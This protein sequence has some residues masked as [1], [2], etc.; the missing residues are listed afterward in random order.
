MSTLLGDPSPK[1]DIE[2]ILVKLPVNSPHLRAQYLTKS[3]V[4]LVNNKVCVNES[5]SPH[6]KNS[7]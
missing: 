3:D 4:L 5:S 6:E 2:E 7:D 1:E